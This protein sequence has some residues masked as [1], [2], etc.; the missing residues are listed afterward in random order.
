[1]KEIPI[2]N[3]EYKVIV[4]WGSKK[5]IKEVLTKNGHKFTDKD[6]D[7]DTCRGRFFSTPFRHSVIALPRK[8]KTAEEIGTLTHEACHAVLDI[9]EWIEEEHYDEVFAHSV[10]AI[11]RESLKG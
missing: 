2:L 7:W 9:F 5:S 11:V 3:N 6:L 4:C 1:M 8:P 10:G